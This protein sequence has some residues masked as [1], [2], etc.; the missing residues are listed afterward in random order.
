MNEHF[1]K[2]FMAKFAAPGNTA[3]GMMSKVRSGVQGQNPVGKI[4]LNTT[5][6]NTSTGARATAPA[7]PGPK[8]IVKPV[9]NTI[10]AMKPVKP[11]V[12]KA[13]GV[14]ATTL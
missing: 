7:I 2:G 6:P 3:L 13:R 12:Q 1:L 14:G 11:I 4:K 5:A 10:P 9:A 8:P